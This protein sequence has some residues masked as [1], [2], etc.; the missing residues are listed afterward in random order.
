MEFKKVFDLIGY[1]VV[2]VTIVF[3]FYSIIG[4]FSDP[5]LQTALLT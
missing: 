4:I 5:I 2:V 1:L 3:T